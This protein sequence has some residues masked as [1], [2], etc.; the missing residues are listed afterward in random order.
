MYDSQIKST[1]VLDHKEDCELSSNQV[2][3]TVPTGNKMRSSKWEEY[4]LNSR[5]RNDWL[6]LQEAYFP[7]RQGLRMERWAKQS[8]QHRSCQWLNGI[9]VGLFLKRAWILDI[10]RVGLQGGKRARN[11]ALSKIARITGSFT[12]WKCIG[13]IEIPPTIQNLIE[14]K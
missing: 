7:V 2:R 4:I 1:L 13:V 9:Y 10:K 12:G 3:D 14:M 11:S 6:E 5:M 8:I